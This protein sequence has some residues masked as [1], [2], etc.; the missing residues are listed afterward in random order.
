MVSGSAE[1]RDIRALGIRA[2]CGA[3][4]RVD[5]WHS[6][7]PRSDCLSADIGPVVAVAPAV[8]GSHDSNTLEQLRDVASGAA[9]AVLM[10]DGARCIDHATLIGAADA[11]TST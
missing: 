4:G 7:H 10:A 6:A 3:H 2:R 9:R 8:F 11:D 5:L 1:V